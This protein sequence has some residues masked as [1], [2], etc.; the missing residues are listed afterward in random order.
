LGIDIT[1]RLCRS[2]SQRPTSDRALYAASDSPLLVICYHTRLHTIRRRSV[3][4]CRA[5]P[6]AAVRRSQ[7][8]DDPSD[9]RIV[10][11]DWANGTPYRSLSAAKPKGALACCAAQITLAWAIRPDLAA[12]YWPIA[13]RTLLRL[14]GLT[15]LCSILPMPLS[16][17]PCSRYPL[18]NTTFGHSTHV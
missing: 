11:S 15:R 16:E 8:I 17:M 14:C 18:C 12:R 9:G 4:A 13:L 3:S 1:A 5:A 7:A 10:P 6:T 2:R